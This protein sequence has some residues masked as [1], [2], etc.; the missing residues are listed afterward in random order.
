M[1][2]DLA[3]QGD[4][5]FSFYK[6]YLVLEREGAHHGALA[7]IEDPFLNFSSFCIPILKYQTFFTNYYSYH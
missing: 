5:S 2:E 7:T 1:G 3:P 6:V 4:K